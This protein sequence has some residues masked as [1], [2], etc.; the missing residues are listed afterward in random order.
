MLL[1]MAIN[2][3][4]FTDV[5]SLL[6]LLHFYCSQEPQVL[7]ALGKFCC[8][9]LQNHEAATTAVDFELSPHTLWVIKTRN[10]HCS[11]TTGGKTTGR[12]TLIVSKATGTEANLAMTP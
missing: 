6:A 12:K 4:C 2:I 9:L 5:N 10:K 3:M 11:L 1:S 7:L 8:F